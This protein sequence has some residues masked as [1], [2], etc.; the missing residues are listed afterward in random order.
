M[1]DPKVTK[2]VKFSALDSSTAD[3]FRCVFTIK[4]RNQPLIIV[5]FD[6]SSLEDEDNNDGDGF[7]NTTTAALQQQCSVNWPI[8]KG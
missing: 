1:G 7:S 2:A 5:I 8:A 4:F 6:Q 3:F